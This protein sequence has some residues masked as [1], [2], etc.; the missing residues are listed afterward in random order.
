MRP[1]FYPLFASI[2]LFADF[3]KTAEEIVHAGRVLNLAG[4]CPATSGNFSCKADEGLIAVTVSGK[5]KGELTS[6]DVILVD[7]EGI[8]QNT[9]KKPSAETLLH[10]ILYQVFP[11]VGAALHTHSANAI[12]L[13]RLLKEAPA[14]TTEGYE[15][16]KAFRGIKTHDSTLT[17]P[18]FENS[19]DYPA[20]SEEVTNYLLSHPDTV[21]FLLRGHGIYTWGKDMKE[22]LIR[23]EALENLFECELKLRLLKK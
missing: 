5:H 13:T 15:I 18:I 7:L 1:Y 11:D 8:P 21:A 12:V 17:F 14:L 4:L 10:T 22:A 20:L 23:V 3:E 6:D 16:H 9:E 19:Q 2:A